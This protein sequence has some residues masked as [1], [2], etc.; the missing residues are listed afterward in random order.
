M[1][2]AFVDCIVRKHFG[3]VKTCQTKEDPPVRQLACLMDFSTPCSENIE[4]LAKC[5][6]AI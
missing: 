5:L 6:T 3:K 4:D 1:E 2:D